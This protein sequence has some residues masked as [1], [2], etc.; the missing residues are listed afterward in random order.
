[1]RPGFFYCSDPH[2]S[3]RGSRQSNPVAMWA[4]GGVIQFSRHSSERWNLVPLASRL[5]KQTPACAGVTL[6]QITPPITR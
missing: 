1:M 5:R 6:D 4:V 3:A 2:G